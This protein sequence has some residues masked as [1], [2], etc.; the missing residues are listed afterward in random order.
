MIASWKL[1]I[2]LS[3]TQRA[4]N[5]ASLRLHGIVGCIQLEFSEENLTAQAVA[6]LLG[7]V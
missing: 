3:G 5:G 2:V 4:A 6:H 1:I 7:G